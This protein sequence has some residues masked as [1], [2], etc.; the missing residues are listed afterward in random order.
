MPSGSY[1]LNSDDNKRA[2]AKPINSIESFEN[3]ENVEQHKCLSWRTKIFYSF[4]H[5]YNG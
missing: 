3:T 2:T 4:G 1:N 5:M